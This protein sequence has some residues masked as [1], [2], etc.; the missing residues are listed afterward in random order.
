MQAL[1]RAASGT[2][3]TLHVRS[4]I[5]PMKVKDKRTKKAPKPVTKPVTEVLSHPLPPEW[6]RYTTP[7]YYSWMMDRIPK[8]AIPADW[9]K[10]RPHNSYSPLFWYEDKSKICVDCGCSFVFS[11]EDQVRWYEELKI[12]IYAEAN[13][14]KECRAAIRNAKA[15]QKAHMQ[16]MQNIA[17]HPNELFFRRKT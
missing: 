6:P 11:K 8:T 5:Y 17:P 2:P 9:S 12:P 15:A 10:H 16:E 4:F 7:A 3:F 1:G 14:C 13:R